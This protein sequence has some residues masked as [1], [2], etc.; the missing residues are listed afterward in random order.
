MAR[1]THSPRWLEVTT[2]AE[3]VEIVR[4]ASR[5]LNL[6]I[7]V[8]PPGT[9]KTRTVRAAVGP[10]AC[11]VSGHLTAFEFYRRLFDHRDE[12]VVIDDV[13]GLHRDREAVRL[14]K[15]LC[16][17]ERRKHVQWNSRAADLRAGAIPTQFATCSRVIVVGNDWATL[18]LDVAALEDRGLVVLF[19]P[20]SREVHLRVA[21]FMTTEAQ[22]VFDYIGQRL[23]LV[24]QPPSMRHYLRGFEL[25]RAGLDWRRALDATCFIRGPARIVAE[26]VSDTN[27]ASE[28]DRV[29]AFM[30]KSGMCRATYFNLKKK[31]PP[32]E[33]VP[34]LVLRRQDSV[35]PS[36]LWQRWQ[37]RQENN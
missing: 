26:L 32:K 10:H 22:E 30:E 36:I 34:H 6:L 4:A 18:S 16:S 15:A 1:S 8:G 28:E 11:W 21:E 9:Q 5:H 3:F 37:G 2:Y 19:Q 25:M 14:L 20:S 7:V 17:T 29:R 24:E 33:E 12:M 35:L 31:L 23:H 27:Y 13:D